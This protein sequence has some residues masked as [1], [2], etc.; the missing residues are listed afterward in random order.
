MKKSS[1]SVS[2][3]S[4]QSQSSASLKYGRNAFTETWKLAIY[5]WEYENT[6]AS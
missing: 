4:R 3:I 1:K 6:G 2:T 5:T